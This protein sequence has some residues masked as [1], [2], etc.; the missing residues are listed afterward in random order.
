MTFALKDQLHYAEVAGEMIFLDLVGDRYFTLP[1]PLKAAFR[2]WSTGAGT[3]NPDLLLQLVRLEVLQAADDITIRRPSRI[4]IAESALPSGVNIQPLG[5][6]RALLRQYQTMWCMRRFSLIRLLAWAT[7]DV[8]PRTRGGQT[9]LAIA[10]AFARSNALISLH[11]NCLMKSAALLRSARLNGH[12]AQ[13]VL[14]VQAK[15][16]AAH[17][18]VQWENFVLNDDPDHVR[19]F[20]P[21][22]SLQ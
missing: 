12:Q 11:D 18:W 16:F 9:P 22:L 1:D 17:C 3:S 6:P 19:T 5:L 13:M 7:A 4:P 2:D 10:A 21:I 20:T 14:G 8:S 15:P